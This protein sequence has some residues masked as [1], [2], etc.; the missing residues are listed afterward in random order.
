MKLYINTKDQK[1]ITV[2]LKKDGRDI[3]IMTDKNKYGSQALLPLILK[4][5][6]K[7]KLKFKDLKGIG[8][9][10]GPG[11]FT[12]LKVGVAVA[13]ALGYSLGILV[14]KKNLESNLIYK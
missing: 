12:G 13:N 5:L 7:N 10:T 6:K 2:A 8:V 1:I 14:N 9:E 11:S 3:D 4:I